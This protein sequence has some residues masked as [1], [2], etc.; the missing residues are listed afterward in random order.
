MAAVAVMNTT[1][2]Q[3]AKKKRGRPKK[4]TKDGG[5]GGKKKQKKSPK[6]KR[7][8]K[9]KKEGPKRGLSA[10]M[11][12]VKEMRPKLRKENLELDFSELGKAVGSSW[13]ALDEEKR[14]PYMEMAVRDKQRF[15]EAKAEFEMQLAKSDGMKDVDVVDEKGN[16]GAEEEPKKAKRQRAKKGSG[17][18]A[19]A[20]KKDKEAKKASTTKGRKSKKV[21]MEAAVPIMA[22]A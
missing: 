3:E 14:K 4:E 15:L 9:K 17:T 2:G 8:A 11:F 22:V 10:Y 13:K 7:T 5:A 16:E 21:E 20:P 12:Y 6:A 18:T 1:D 19:A